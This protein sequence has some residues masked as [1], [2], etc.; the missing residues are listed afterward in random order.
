MKHNNAATRAALLSVLETLKPVA[1]ALGYEWFDESPDPYN[2]SELANT[3]GMV[4]DFIRD[5]EF[6]FRAKS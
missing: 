3:I 4:A 6:E 5:A 1:V 2:N